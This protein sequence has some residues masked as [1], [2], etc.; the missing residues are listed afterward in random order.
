MNEKTKLLSEHVRDTSSTYDSKLTVKICVL[1]NSTSPMQ[2]TKTSLNHR[3][4]KNMSKSIT[5]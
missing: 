2:R 1:T 5:H 4:N 3:M